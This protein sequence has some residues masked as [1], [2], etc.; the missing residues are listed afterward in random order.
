MPSNLPP[1][2]PRKAPEDAWNG[3]GAFPAGREEVNALPPALAVLAQPCACGHI[4]P[5]WGCDG[6]ERVA[7]IVATL[8]AVASEVGDVDYR[9]AERIDY[10]A[11][12]IEKGGTP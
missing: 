1:I 5:A 9:L 12:Q 11:D 2:P 3:A 4:N 10:W 7:T 6:C 8:R